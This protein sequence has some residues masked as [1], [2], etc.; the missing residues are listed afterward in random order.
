MTK[1]EREYAQILN[2]VPRLTWT[3]QTENYGLDY[4][5]C[6]GVFEDYVFDIRYDYD[7]DATQKPDCGLCMTIY[8]KDKAVQHLFGADIDSLKFFAKQFIMYPPL[9]IT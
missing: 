5:S 6:K 4:T 3:E 8:V 7:G 9:S 2:E 1:E